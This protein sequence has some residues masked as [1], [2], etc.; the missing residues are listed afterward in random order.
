[1]TE[2]NGTRMPILFVVLTL[3]LNS[4]GVGLILPVMPD[5]ILDV[6]GGNLSHAAV[7][8]GILAT[9]YAVMQFFFAPAVGALSDRFGRRPILLLSLAVM[10]ADY[11]VLSLA[12]SIWLLFG[13]RL[14]GGITSATQSTASALISDLSSPK[15]KAKN[16]GLVG[17]A[18]GI[19]FVLGPMAGGLLAEFGPRVPFWVAAGLTTAN[20]V[21]GASVVQE[22]V[23]D[24]IRRPFELKRAN[25][26]AAFMKIR[27]LPGVLPL[28][29]LFF[30]YEFAFLVFP[31]TWAYFTQLRFGWTAGTVGLSLATF[32]MAMAVVQGGL[33][34]FI[35]PKLGESGTVVWGF[36]FNALAFA[37][38]ALISN[39]TVALL[40]APLSALGAVVS[41]TLQSLMSNATSK[42][43]Q[44]ELQG[45]LASTRA[46]AMI[47]SPLVMT[48]IF[49]KFSD[50][51][52]LVHFPG[53]A[54]T[55]A[56]GLMLVALVITFA[57]CRATPSNANA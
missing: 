56:A 32:G 11:I 53:A 17:A 2:N 33:I 46:I 57:R 45:V 3:T 14:V 21:F 9:C 4:M 36:I 25:P 43:R 52:N 29:S 42:S 15:D 20:F 38:L 7:W 51:S 1:M 22:T 5:L 44:G 27:E 6:T 30:L 18:F 49:S 48:Q 28:L 10:A 50:T 39:G 55:I 35:V 12:G 19:G 16:F 54:F 34:R 40:L 13:A 8:G 37:A 41:P 31:S 26:F 24:T 47:F 23:T